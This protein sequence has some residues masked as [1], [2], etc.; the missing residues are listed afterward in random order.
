M[1]SA[2]MKLREKFKGIADVLERY[3]ENIGGVVSFVGSTM[4][5][6]NGGSSNIAAASSFTA[7]ELAFMLI[8]A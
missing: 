8:A 5:L 2:S 1:T 7:A 6:L 4:L 3:S